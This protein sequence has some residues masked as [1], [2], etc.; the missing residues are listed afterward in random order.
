MTSTVFAS[1]SCN[2]TIGEYLSD[3]LLLPPLDEDSIDD[4]PF[5]NRKEIISVV[6]GMDDES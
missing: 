2:A 4:D 6:V 1:V 5:T 3:V